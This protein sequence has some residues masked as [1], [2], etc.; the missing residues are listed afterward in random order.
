MMTDAMQSPALG[1]AYEPLFRIGAAV[2]SRMTAM[3]QM[4]AIFN[5]MGG[6]SAASLAAVSL[7]SILS[8]FGRYHAEPSL[9]FRRRHRRRRFRD[10]GGADGSAGPRTPGYPA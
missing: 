3:P 10:P 5:G 8:S 4:V 6:G 7:L 2:S 1:R 9:F